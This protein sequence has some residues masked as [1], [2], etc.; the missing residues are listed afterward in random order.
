MND[1]IRLALVICIVWIGLPVMHGHAAQAV[2]EGLDP[3]VWQQEPR[4]SVSHRIHMAAQAIDG[5]ADLEYLFNCIEDPDLGSRWQASTVYIVKG[6]K[7]Q[8]TYTFVA[9]VRDKATGQPVA[10]DARSIRVVTPAA[11]KFDRLIDEDIEVIPI[12][13]NGDKDNRINILIMNRW[14][15]GEKNGYNRPG[16]RQEFIDDVKHTCR[17]FTPGDALAEKP[18]ANFS[19][20]FNVYALWW[21]EIPAYRKGWTHTDYQ[22]LRDRLFLPWQTEGRGWASLM[23]MLNS[24]G[25]GGGAGRNLDRRV[26]DAMITGNEIGKFLH[27]FSHT[28]MGCGDKYIGWGTWGGQHAA[29]ETFV[30]THWYLRDHLPWKAWVEDDTPIPTPYSKKHFENTGVYEGGI[31]RLGHIFRSSPYCIMGVNQFMEHLCDTCVQRGAGRV[32]KWVD[33]FD[34]TT[35]IRKALKLEQP[36]L[37]RFSIDRVEGTPDQQAVEWRLNGKVIARDVDEVE[38]L[39]GAIDDYELTC[40]ILDHTELIRHDPPYASTPKAE[41]SW[42]IK[43]PSP[44][45]QWPP[46]AVSVNPDNPGCWGRSNGAVNVL[47]R[48]GR[49][50]YHYQWSNGS[51]D[52]KVTGLDCGHYTVDIID[53]EFRHATASC[54]LTRPLSLKVDVQSQW[55]TDA[56]QIALE[57]M[58]T[59]KEDVTCAW[60][61]GETSRTLN[62]IA[63]GTCGYVLTHANGDSLSGE[64]TVRKPLSPL[65]LTIGDVMPSAGENNGE[66]RL[67]VTGGRPPYQITWSDGKGV[68]T[69]ER[70]FLPPGDYSVTVKDENQTTLEETITV[71]EVETFIFERPEFD[72]SVTGLVR[73][74]KPRKDFRYIWYDADHPMHVNRAPRGLYEGHF[75]SAD[76]TKVQATGSLIASFNG[77]W[78]TFPA[79]RRNPNIKNDYSSWI[80]LE[81]YFDGFNAKPKTLKFDTGHSGQPGESLDLA[82]DTSQEVA[83]IGKYEIPMKADWRGWIKQG[84]LSLVGEGPDGGRFDLRYTGRHENPAK[85]LHVGS[86]FRPEQPGNYYV[87]A[88]KTSSGAISFNR[89]G[90]AVIQ[91]APSTTVVPLLPDAVTSGKLL[92]WLD[93][94]DINAD[95]KVDA[96]LWTSERGIL[97]GWKDK[98][99]DHVFDRIHYWPNAQN[100][101]AVA[102]FKYLWVQHF[103]ETVGKF[104]T[105][106]MVYR[107]HELSQTGSS[108]WRGTGLCFWDLTDDPAALEK[109]PAAYRDARAYCNGVP[110][111]PYA[112]PAPLDEYCVAT[113]ELPQK[114][115]SFKSANPFWEGSLGEILVFDTKLSENERQGVEEYLR[116]KWVSTVS[117]E[118]QP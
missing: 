37:A 115:G 19:Q 15:S 96:E 76:G 111:D 6:L 8:S 113:F 4:A 55:R 41:V 74:L 82:V 117:L 30:S 1:K 23:A 85:R 71:S 91:A 84:R 73:I 36:G 106:I 107:D 79:N 110:V 67:N 50:P 16:L 40:S 75:E 27:E 43:N 33:V 86:E 17:A 47:A 22:T 78:V 90:V 60:S 68:D 69:T 104:Q 83:H 54:T 29:D 112:T 118:K 89:I 65:I 61:T 70:E 66:I 80:R 103:K 34:A 88:Q 12:I 114:N 28:A 87:A 95:G 98:A 100:G 64:V 81:A 58:G 105:V 44:Q 72:R 5:A 56:W 2:F 25:G 102:D 46:L 26:G 11:G 63:D 108:M 10:A 93:P 18:F 3:L 35:P 21:P 94:S 99:G 14:T 101:L 52:E 92:L 24:D 9:K 7:P 97:H 59:G 48:G 42:Q 45:S 32:Y 49:P 39:L 116:R 20:F 62:G 13:E 51:H 57:I 77:K 31:H 38:V 53:S 109:V